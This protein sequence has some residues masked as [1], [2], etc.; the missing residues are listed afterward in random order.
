MGFVLPSVDVM[1]IDLHMWKNPCILG[2]NP[3]DGGYNLF[4]V[5]LDLIW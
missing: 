4:Y 5:L 3:L 2:I 1:F